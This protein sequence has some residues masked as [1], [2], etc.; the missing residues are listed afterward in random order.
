LMMKTCLKNLK[1]SLL[2]ILLLVPVISASSQP[3]AASG[4]FVVIADAILSIDSSGANTVL[5]TTHVSQWTGT[6]KGKSVINHET[7]TIFPDGSV[8]DTGF[9]TFVTDDGTGTADH[10]YFAVGNIG[11]DGQYGTADDTLTGVFF[12]DNGTGSLAGIRARGKFTGVFSGTYEG[13]V[14]FK[15]KP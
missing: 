13:T 5:T 11:P 14:S 1:F 6:F 12:A 10:R 15:D 4:T 7:I 8:T 3:T 9:G 2:G